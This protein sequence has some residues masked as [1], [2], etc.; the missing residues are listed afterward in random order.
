METSMDERFGNLVEALSAHISLLRSSGLNE[1]ARLL[2]MAQLE[3]RLH[4]HSI[5]DRE[6]RELCEL[7]GQHARDA[8]IERPAARQLSSGSTAG[9]ASSARIEP[10]ESGPLRTKNPRKHAR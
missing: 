4:V 5:S 1:S 6:L 8:A 3:I 9:R 10:M 2:E 7:A